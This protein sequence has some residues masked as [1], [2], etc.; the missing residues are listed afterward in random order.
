MN[1]KIQLIM[2]I[3]C[4]AVLILRSTPPYSRMSLTNLQEVADLIR[5][6][7]LQCVSSLSP[8][9]ISPQ[10]AAHTFSA[11]SSKIQGSC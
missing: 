11:G 6:R 5:V 10:A 9:G 4:P 7:F 8:A 3:S 2:R 1:R